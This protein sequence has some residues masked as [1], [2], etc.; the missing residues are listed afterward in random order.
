MVENNKNP[1][2]LA[3]EISQV[4]QP[5]QTEMPFAVV[6]GKEITELP[7]DLYIPPMALGFYK[8]LMAI[9]FT[10]LVNFI[11]YRRTISWPYSRNFSG[12]HCR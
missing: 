5:Q 8:N 1:P 3:I 4:G 7:K 12:V 6:M 2:E 11:L 10:K 9:L